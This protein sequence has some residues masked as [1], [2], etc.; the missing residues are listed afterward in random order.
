MSLQ[1]GGQFGRD[2]RPVFEVFLMGLMG[3]RGQ[4]C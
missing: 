2:F 4:G 1:R 3:Y